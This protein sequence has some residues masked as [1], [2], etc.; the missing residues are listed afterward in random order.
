MINLIVA[1]LNM[2]IAGYLYSVKDSCKTTSSIIVCYFL[3]V[4]NF[5]SAILNLSIFIKSV[6]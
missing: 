5:L 6:L 3:M 4:V 1:L 2:L